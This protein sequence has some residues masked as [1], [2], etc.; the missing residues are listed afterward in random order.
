MHALRRQAAR[1]NYENAGWDPLLCALEGGKARHLQ[2]LDF[3]IPPEDFGWYP[4]LTCISAIRLAA[5]FRHM[6][7]LVH[8]NLYGHNIG[9]AGALAL[10]EGLQHTPHLRILHLSHDKIM[11]EG[12]QVIAGVFHKL[13]E[14]ESLRM[15]NCGMLSKGAHMLGSSFKFLPRLTSLGF[16]SLNYL[17]QHSPT[18]DPIFEHLIDLPNLNTLRWG[19]RLISSQVIT[20]GEQLQCLP[21][22]RELHLWGFHAYGDGMEALGEVLVDLPWLEH[23]IIYYHPLRLKARMCIEF[24]NSLAACGFRE[25]EQSPGQMDAQREAEESALRRMGHLGRLRASK[26]TRTLKLIRVLS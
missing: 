22:L 24:K 5:S 21:K 8:L 9:T 1:E 6:P 17:K 10:A 7:A 23:I 15:H 18:A 11:D 4:R 12:I 20:L 19:G 14:L 3:G 13:P 2:R 16:S 26:M 25:E